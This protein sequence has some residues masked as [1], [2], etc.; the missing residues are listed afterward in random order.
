MK[1][2]KT[3]FA[4]VLC[5]FLSSVLYAQRET[6]SLRGIVVEKEGGPLPGVAITATS[7]ALQGTAS[8]VSTAT[9]EFRM[10]A[11]PPGTYEITAKLQGFKTMKMEGIIVHLGMNVEVNISMETSP[12]AEEV[13]VTAPSPVVDVSNSKLTQTITTDAIQNLP[14]N[15]TVWNLAMLS[16]GVVTPVLTTST[17]YQINPSAF[18]SA[19]PMVAHGAAGGQNLF[20]VDGVGM[21]DT[22]YNTPGTNISFDIMDEIEMITGG[23]PAEIG[24]TSGVFINVVTKSG[25]NRFSGE[26]LVSYTNEHLL[27]VVF[28]DT[29]L[30]AMGL[31]KPV[32]P[33]YD[34]DMTANFG[35]PIFKDKLWFFGSFNWLK[36]ENHAGFRPITWM[37]K[38]YEDFNTTQRLWKG[39]FKLTGQVSRSLRFQAMFHSTDSWSPW[40]GG[41]TTPIEA[42]TGELWRN[43]VGTAVMQWVLDPNTFLHVRGGFYQNH[44]TR[45]KQP[46]TESLDIWAIR[47]E[48]LGYRF[49]TAQMAQYGDRDAYRGSADLSHFEDDFLGGDHE[50][51]AGLELEF[52]KEIYSYWGNSSYPWHYYNESPYYYRA[53]FGQTDPVYG[54]GWITLIPQPFER[55]GGQEGVH[56]GPV[57][58]LIKF[59]AYVQDSWTIKRRLTINAGLRFDY[60]NAWAPALTFAANPKTIVDIGDYYYKNDPAVDFNPFDT[61]EF[62]KWEDILDWKTISPRLGITYDLFGNGKTALKASYS[63]LSHG[64]ASTDFI[65][66]HPFEDH[67]FDFNWWDLNNNGKLDSPPIDL[68]QPFGTSPKE[69]LTYK[70]LMSPDLVSPYFNEV[71]AGIKHELAANVSVGLTYVY[72]NAKNLFGAAQYDLSSQRWWGTYDQAPDWWVPFTTIVPAYGDFSEKQVTMY[73][74]SNNAPGQ[75]TTKTDNLSYAKLN[76]K[77][78]EFS[79]DKRMS[80]GW[81]LGGSVTLSKTEG[82]TNQSALGPIYSR[83]FQNPNNLVN[84]LGRT[85]ND[86][87]VFIKLYGT[88]SLPLKILA[89]FSY[90][91]ASGSPFTRT[92]RIYPPAAWSA[93]NNVNRLYTYTINVEPAG[94]SRL[95]DQ[96]QLDCRFEKRVGLGKI[97]SL[98][99]FL[100]IFNILGTTIVNVNQDPA[101]TWRPV[102]ANTNVGTFTP[103]GSY[104]RITSVNGTRIFK[105]SARFMF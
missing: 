26:G 64:L 95:I 41:G 82:N 65:S 77:G 46:G 74:M 19:A 27:N 1:L 73:F 103:T 92:V 96:S 75:L 102:D 33:I 36:N 24:T 97:G 13:I 18:R 83:D 8:V 4:L 28:P 69:M 45:A 85:T 88:F 40:S 50:F 53:Q 21:N 15:R 71:M 14:V 25:G 47:D 86:R 87:P 99:V 60:Y 55:D 2:C 6:G 10:P 22:S 11:L 57:A 3:L 38:T 89:S 101:G 105:L 58:D 20:K 37:G 94:S 59:G 66:L 43:Y 84:K 90:R 48:Y 34:V 80:N 7:P 29:Q 42:T 23:L 49:G 93:A 81:Q 76:Y 32:A 72:K 91:Y 54:D 70:E 35:G 17:A 31:G 16:P 62:P 52:T 67:Y 56:G 30:K 63:K 79:F 78:F 39:F 98:G 104:A 5:F 68:Y 51:K 44:N 9:G 12:L 100:D 61:K